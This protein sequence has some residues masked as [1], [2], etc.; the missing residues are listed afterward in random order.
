MTDP[1]R[2]GG[3]GGVGLG[4]FK[5]GGGG[6]SRYLIANDGANVASM[7]KYSAQ[8]AWANGTI[9]DEAYLSTLRW[10]VGQTDKGSRE[11]VAAEN[12]LGDAVYTIGRNKIVRAVNNAATTVQRVSA[13]RKLIGYDQ[14]KLRGMQRSNEQYRELQDKIA[15]SESAIR[16]ARYGDLVRRFNQE[17]V[18]LDSLLS[19]T[20]SMAAQARGSQ[21]AQTWQDRVSQ[22]ED[23][24]WTEG[25][26]A[27]YQDYQMGRAKGAQV[28]GYLKAH[29]A[30]M[31]HG[32]PTY[33]DLARRVEDLTKQ[34]TE[35]DRSDKDA[36]MA[37]KV[38]DGNITNEAYLQY[39]HGRI[40]DYPQGS[41]ERK[42]AQET[43]MH[44][45]FNFGEA[46]IQR[47]INA[48]TSTNQDL[49]DFYRSYM[50]TMNPSAAAY[51]DLQSKISDLLV[52]GTGLIAI[53]GN[54]SGPGGSYGAYAGAGHWVD[55]SGSPGGTPV[56]GQG[57]AS[58]FDGSTF[59]NTNC[60]MA[61]GAMLA[62]A[63]SGG[64]VRV[65][66]GD[67]RYYSGDRD[68][69]GDEKG[70][71]LGDLG[72][73]FQ[74]I[75]MGLEEH[76]GMAFGSWKQRLARG[77]GSVL[78]GNYALVPSNLRI[79]S[80]QGPHAVYV[81]RARKMPDGQW[82][83]FV[84]DPQGRTNAQIG[85][86]WPESAI[87]TFAWNGGPTSGGSTWNGHVAFATK[88]GRSATFISPDRESPPA[89]AFDTD[90]NG[91]STVGRGGG[92]DRAEAG[93]RHDWSKGRQADPTQQPKGTDT[94]TSGTAQPNGKPRT[95]SE[96]DVAEFLAAVDSVASPDLQNP[97]TWGARKEPGTQGAAYDRQQRAKA[98]LDANGGDARL[99]A[100]A[101]F[102]PAGTPDKVPTD[103]ATW[104]P[105]QR[106]YANAIGT[107][108]G[109]DAVPRGGVGDI[110]PTK[111]PRPLD[112]T[113]MGARP[114]YQQGQALDGLP[115]EPTDLATQF[116]TQLGVKA[117]P[118]MVRAVVAWMATEGKDISGNNPFVLRTNGVSD[119][120]GQVGK[121]ADGLA[122]FGTPEDGIKA[123]VA[124]V[125]REQ[126]GII[127]AARSGD[128][129]VFLANVDRSGWVQG[130]Y[131]GTLVRTY[132]EL[133]GSEGRTIIGGIG[134][135]LKGPASLTGLASM[136]PGVAELFDVDPRDPVQMRWLEANVASAKA[137][138]AA[139]ASS[140]DFLTP[141][142]QKVTLPF[143]PNMSV[144]LADTKA[145][146]L[147][148]N[149][150]NAVTPMDRMEAATK[151]QQAH[152]DAIS[153]ASLTGSMQF[154]RWDNL[155]KS[156]QRVRDYAVGA[157]DWATYFNQTA[158][159][160]AATAAAFGFDPAAPSISVDSLPG[161]A[162]LSASD[163]DH[164]SRFID[165]MAAQGTQNPDGD[166][167]LALR[168]A[169][170]I[171]VQKDPRTGRAVAANLDP[172]TAYVEAT[173][174]GSW[175]LVTALKN[176][177][178]FQPTPLVDPVTGQDRNVPAYM[179]DTAFVVAD[180][181][182]KRYPLSSGTVR[183]GVLVASGYKTAPV[184]AVEPTVAR[185][186]AIRSTDFTFDE[187]TG[188]FVPSG[189]DR[190]NK[191]PW[192][193]I[194][195]GTVTNISSADRQDMQIVPG[196]QIPVQTIDINVR[197]PD[198]KM[199]RQTWYSIPG[200]GQWIGGDASS[201]Y[202]NPLQLIV[203]ESD[204]WALQNGTLMHGG[205]AYDPTTDSTPLSKGIHWYGTDPRDAAPAIAAGTN[206]ANQGVP[207]LGA[208]DSHYRLRQAIPTPGGGFAFDTAPADPTQAFLEGDI[209]FSSLLGAYGTSFTRHQLTSYPGM[210]NAVRPA[211][212]AGSLAARGAGAA[213][214]PQRTFPMTPV[215][216]LP[217][218]PK[219]QMVAI[220]QSLDQQFNQNPI[221]GLD[222]IAR[223]NLPMT[224]GA[225]P[226]VTMGPTLGSAMAGFAV[227]LASGVRAASDAAVKAAE[228]QR[229]IARQQ[230]LVQQQ[231]AAQQAAA[232]QAQAAQQAK[233]R[234]VAVPKQLPIATTPIAKA[235]PKPAPTPTPTPS[236]SPSPAPAPTPAPKP[237]PT[238]SPT[239][240]G[241]Y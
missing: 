21:D 104:T 153:E 80:F 52:S 65:S 18:S 10:Y 209:S 90:A 9:T 87:K 154:D 189:S 235:T 57:F 99:A 147:E 109:Y 93:P 217:G 96:G 173:P 139:G 196:G 132:N 115:K 125:Q 6:D 119:L 121:T 208:P 227:R 12:E 134:S 23:Q 61:S 49:V 86:W 200:S 30:G 225:R 118:D 164:L 185:T 83:Y 144:D 46:D 201:L 127:A 59:A 58:Q 150:V 97:D 146:Y 94:S 141:G 48:G 218:I 54:G 149:A 43:W 202:N 161:A 170:M 31:D 28:I 212:P 182:G 68:Q 45:A 233:L 163:K 51:L 35:K 204:G 131:G 41:S 105:T 19:F 223:M 75:G 56:N 101:W 24:K 36:E 133:P 156:M 240:H 239:Q 40:K 205:K 236:P 73:A 22:L 142:G 128:P 11:R 178:R 74:H 92:K 82:W 1:F 219:D 213:S 174:D 64:K 95:A 111:P 37:A 77:E 110:D 116:L 33:T 117:T 85:A 183:M 102:T 107:R 26:N 192:G 241:N 60:T 180:G 15:S 120:P 188:Q 215:A 191:D 203:N 79:S 148:W 50:A 168:E 166:P 55:L 122:I 175:K 187:T 130:G 47:G 63:A 160:Y 78:Q 216:D 88:K 206:G 152:K 197:Q 67:L 162:F 179:I 237:V 81:D 207:E 126:P 135:M 98:L 106:F 114:D 190:L 169:G 4:P 224:A 69:P 13:L 53:S 32:T 171:Q 199:V 20:R 16:D 167:Y 137:A 29:M 113:T 220:Q 89:Q 186:G 42:Q 84:M 72:T 151:A 34:V 8:V 112:M 155:M 71:G 17:Q 176:P 238:P 165:G 159:M 198:G 181:Q 140:W 230:A 184:M 66:G 5:T 3:F 14:A 76:F 2:G 234:D 145:Q 124:A 228:A 138:N 210:A 91:Q 172:T 39:L 70:T 214:S 108:L 222:A 194:R 38:Q 143:S 123:A 44:T 158:D 211:G 62:W 136:E 229:T 157:G 103:T 226:N 193:S 195:T 221:P 27:L 100:I 232:E 129:E 7:R 177:E 231:L 25:Y